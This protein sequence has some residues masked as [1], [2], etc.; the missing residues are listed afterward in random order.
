MGIFGSRARV[1]PA[2]GPEAGGGVS[3]SVIEA[4]PPRFAAV[5][6]AIASGPHSAEPLLV[7]GREL[8]RDGIAL[9]AVLE[10]LQIVSLRLTGRDPEFAD[11]RAVSLGWSEAMLGYFH[12]L[13]CEDSMTGLSSLAHLRSRLA[14]HYRGRTPVRDT[15]ALVVVDVVAPASGAP[16]AVLALALHLST[17]GDVARTVFGGT[18]T[19]A[20]ASS[21]RLIV[22]ARRDDR[23]GQ[24]VALLRRLLADLDEDEQPRLWIEG[25]PTSDASC[26]GLLDELARG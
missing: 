15:H 8:A 24:R 14:E 11:V 4:V 16:G 18:E 20:R 10:A 12:Q 9:D 13:S 17:V 7:A 1:V 23:L 5:A 19:I 2:V 6:E 22:L 3:D 25:L 26:A 21:H